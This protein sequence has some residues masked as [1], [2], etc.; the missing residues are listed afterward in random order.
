MDQLK[1]MYLL[2]GPNEE[3][4]VLDRREEEESDPKE[5][6]GD[7]LNGE[8]DENDDED[9]PKHGHK[10]DVGNESDG[11]LDHHDKSLDVMNRASE[12]HV[13]F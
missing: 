6:D 13:L 10:E 12:S 11:N 4:N 2:A 1:K 9:H 3:P 8:G 7:K 5:E